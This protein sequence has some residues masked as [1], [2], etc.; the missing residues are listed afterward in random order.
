M[1]KTQIP[2]NGIADDAVG[3][4]KLDLTA[5]YAFTGTVTGTPSDFVKLITTTISS[6]VGSVDF[7]STYINSTYKVYKIYYRGI[8]LTGTDNIGLRI[9]ASG[10]LLTSSNYQKGGFAQSYESTSFSGVSGTTDS[11]YFFGGH[12][13]NSAGGQEMSGEITMYDLVNN[14]PN[15]AVVHI[16]NRVGTGANRFDV[17]GFMNPNTQ[18]C[19]IISLFT[20]GSENMSAG[21]VS[22]YGIKE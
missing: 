9:G 17:K 14:T 19:N 13:E 10:T 11:G 18:T 5:N 22:L 21:Q 12:H 20:I 15:K 6:N 16:G 3:N 8:I 4:T 2:T 1:S 7:G